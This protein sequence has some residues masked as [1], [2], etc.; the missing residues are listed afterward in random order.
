[1]QICRGNSIDRRLT[2]Y[3][4]ITSKLDHCFV[5]LAHPCNGYTAV[6]CSY[7]YNS[8]TR[9]VARKK[10]TLVELLEMSESQ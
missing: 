4:Y 2:V 5:V 8:L 7:C 3:L 9:A 6:S 1:M 10:Q